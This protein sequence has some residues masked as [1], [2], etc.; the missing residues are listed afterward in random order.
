MGKSNKIS[1]SK[2]VL[3]ESSSSSPIRDGQQKF[4]DKVKT[5]AEQ[6]W[7]ANNAVPIDHLPTIKIYIGIICLCYDMFM[8][9][10]TMGFIYHI[11]TWKSKTSLNVH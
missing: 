9:A 4:I 6:S 7:M 3:A 8:N 5:S 2:N 11:N 10:Q 1:N